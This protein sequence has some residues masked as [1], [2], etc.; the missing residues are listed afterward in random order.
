[1][2]VYESQRKTNERT[3][4]GINISFLHRNKETNNESIKGVNIIIFP[5]YFWGIVNINKN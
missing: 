5:G 2:T 1:M 3:G 4:K